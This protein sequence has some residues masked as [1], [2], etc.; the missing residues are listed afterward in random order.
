MTSKTKQ[1]DET[2]SFTQTQIN[3]ANSDDRQIR[4]K[5]SQYTALIQSLDKMNNSEGNTMKNS[6]PNLLNQIM[7]IVP[8]N[9]QIT[10][11]ENTTERHVVI[12]AQSD[13]YEQ[14][15]FL[16]A[17]IKAEDILKNTI[18]T[19]GQKDNRIVTIKIEGELPRKNC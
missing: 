5:T 15:G 11:I 10:S 17:K 3:S 4:D 9:V 14:L 19:S 16:T 6:I 13:K 7:S 8:E 12:T 18:S 1:V 2:I